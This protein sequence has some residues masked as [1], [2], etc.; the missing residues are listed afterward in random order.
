MVLAIDIG[1]SNIV[2]GY[3]DG[4]EIPRVF[5][6]RTDAS[7]TE[8]EYVVALK[9]V[10]ALEPCGGFDGAIISCVV[11]PLTAAVHGAVRRVAGLNAY[12]VGAGMRTG[13]SIRIDATPPRSAATSWPRASR[14][15]S[16]T[17][18]P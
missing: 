6:L 10:L 13:L 7:K 17:S 14:P 15:P 18:C 3:V 5:R 11:P 2:I 1:N 16:C 8:D 4:G 9:Q 12:V